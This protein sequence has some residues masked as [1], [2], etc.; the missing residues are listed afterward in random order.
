MEKVEDSKKEMVNTPDKKTGKA[1]AKGK[2][3]ENLNKFRPPSSSSSS[4]EADPSKFL[5]IP[6]DGGWG[7]IICIASFLC[8]A[9]V[10]YWDLRYIGT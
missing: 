5:P 3:D 2:V 1:K 8:N 4:S 10:G 6:P 9:V 7:W